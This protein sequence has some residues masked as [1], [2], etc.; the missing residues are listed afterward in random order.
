MS[1]RIAFV[2]NLLRTAPDRPQIEAKMPEHTCIR[3]P[4]R[5]SALPIDWAGTQLTDSGENTGLYFS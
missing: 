4:L 1:T 3:Q 2:N 5:N